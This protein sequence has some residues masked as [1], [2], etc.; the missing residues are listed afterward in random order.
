MIYG[1]IDVGSNTI[2]LSIYKYEREELKLL[3]NKKTM[4][5]L[6]GYVKE[7][8]LIEEGI[9]KA[10]DVLKE[11]KEI[12][13]NFSIDKVEVFATASLRNIIN[14]DEAT[15]EIKNKTGF[16]V[17]IL[18]GI[19]EGICDF[20][21]AIHAL[22]IKDGVVVDIGGGSTEIVL[23]KN[24]EIIK[25]YSIPIGSLNLYTSS[26]KELFPTQDERKEII[27]K[28]TGELNKLKGISKTKCKIMC[29]IG[30]TIRATGALN[31]YIFETGLNLKE[32]ETKNV[33]KLIKM[34]KKQDK[35]NLLTIL[36]VVP[37]R[38][39]TIIPGM[40]ILNTIAKYFECEMIHVSGY[41]VREGYLYSKVLGMEVYTNE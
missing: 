6:A 1:I 30:G 11:Y 19:E 3:L 9:K 15:Y 2:R 39:H 31:N 26:I 23:Y 25:V 13:E 27:N 10:C 16:S 38:I 28:V 41:G 14:S 17:T 5:G 22:D 7:G 18:S 40:I 33:K 24:T 37:D 12:I 8:I 35:Q 29:G 21:G 32:I 36:K 34:F 20:A 4:A